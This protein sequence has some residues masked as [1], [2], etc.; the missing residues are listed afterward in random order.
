MTTFDRLRELALEVAI[1]LML[2]S[3]VTPLAGF[4]V[5]IEHMPYGLAVVVLLGK[6]PPLGFLVPVIAGTVFWTLSHF[7]WDSWTNWTYLVQ[8]INVLTPLVFFKDLWP[9]IERT[10]RIVFWVYIGFAILQIFRL[11]VFA[12]PFFE[13]L[14]PRFRGRTENGYRGV[15]SLESEPARAGFQLIMLYIIGR[16]RFR[17]QQI[18]LGAMLL[19]Q[20][21]LLRAT[22]GLTL[23][24]ILLCFLVIAAALYRPKVAPLLLALVVA[25]TSVAYLQNPKVELI[26]NRTLEQ[27]WDGF[28]DSLTA[29]SGGR[30]LALRD[31]VGDIVTQPFGYGADPSYR[32]DELEIV[33]QDRYE[34]DDGVL[35]DIER[36]A[37]P[38]S[39]ILNA[40]RTFGVAM[41]FLVAWAARRELFNSGRP[42]ANAYF[43]FVIVSALIYG[44]SG[45]EALLIALG[46]AGGA[47]RVAATEPVEQRQRA[48][49]L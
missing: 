44:P 41:A 20:V 17:S 39:A 23:S 14:I 43:W 38:V 47:A 11:L 36:A 7:Y 1:A 13:N 34:D 9:R 42:T 22:V 16:A 21:L 25:L 29:A 31:S 45:S 19:A 2:I 10:A 3:G 32:G 26:A 5:G 30:W 40:V 33:D 46:F 15:A 12:E 49:Q 37:R 27:G 24:G 8:F 35:Y 28:D 4:G 6:R 18:A 48:T